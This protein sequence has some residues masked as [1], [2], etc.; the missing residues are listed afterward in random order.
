MLAHLLVGAVAVGQAAAGLDELDHGLRAVA[1]LWS[2]LLK[3]SAAG[4][5]L[6]NSQQGSLYCTCSVFSIRKPSETWL[7]QQGN[8]HRVS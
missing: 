5:Y 1:L 7:I 3:E 4:I 8:T 6:R 2:D